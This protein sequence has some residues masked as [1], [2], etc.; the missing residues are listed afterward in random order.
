MDASVI[1]ISTIAGVAAY[2]LTWQKQRWE[3]PDGLTLK[4]LKEVGSQLSKPHKV[5]FFFMAKTADELNLL[6]VEL[7]GLGFSVQSPLSEVDDG[8]ILEVSKVFVP[9]LRTLLHLR[10]KLSCIGKK[11]SAIYDGWGAEVVS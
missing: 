1:I 7:E 4:R 9:S 6:I 2:L 5:D 8:F 11:Y 3:S 10:K